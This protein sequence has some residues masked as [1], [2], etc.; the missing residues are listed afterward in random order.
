MTDWRKVESFEAD[1]LFWLPENEDDQVAGRIIF[2]PSSGG[3]LELIGNFADI[4]GDELSDQNVLIHGVAGRRY[5]TLRNCFH[6]GY[7]TEYPG[8]R[9]DRYDTGTI[10][11]GHLFAVDDPMTFSEITFSTNNLLAWTGRSAFK[12]RSERDSDGKY[13][14]VAISIS[15]Q[16]SDE[17]AGDSF[18]LEL[19]NTWKVSQGVTRHVIEEDCYLRVAYPSPREYDLIMQD[20][21]ILQDLVTL[22]TGMAAVPSKV[23]LAKDGL[24]HERRPG[25]RK[26]IQIYSGLQGYAFA[27]EQES[28]KMPIRY[29]GIG[30]IDAMARWLTF[31][32]DRKPV[33]DLLLASRYQ[34]MYVENRF[35]SGVSA[36]E[37]LH[38]LEF[39]NEVRPAHEYKAFRRMLVRCVPKPHR[40]WLSQQLAFANEPRLRHRLKELATHAEVSE[41]LGIRDAAKWADHVA[42]MRNRMVHH[43]AAKTESVTPAE[44]HWFAESLNLTVWLSFMKKCSF[45][46]GFR[47]ILK[48][49]P[50]VEYLASQIREIMDQ[51]E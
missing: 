9:R 51:V 24:E 22:A 36:A 26:D 31:S 18:S 39:L 28:R 41:I 33:L 34:K 25:H 49:D 30:G 23:H 3:R 8:V 40:S 50:E 10:L 19:L 38:R 42:N 43:D 5:L 47:E 17:A 48:Q 15:T 2:D 37:T 4:E 27:K 45:A 1:G 21:R 14:G 44:F 11:A 13:R 46:D 6:R 32:R 35:L 20:L 29:A 12:E 7:T 16:D